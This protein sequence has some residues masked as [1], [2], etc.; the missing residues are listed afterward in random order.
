MRMT[1]A[2]RTLDLHGP[3]QCELITQRGY[4]VIARRLGPDPLR[5]D[6]DPEKVW[7][8]IRK[9]RSAIGSLLLNQAIIAG[10]GNVYRAEILFLSGVCPDRPGNQID[11]NEFDQIWQLSVDLL[12]VGV[13]Y[14]RIVTAGQNLCAQSL[15]RS[16]TRELTLIYQS[17]S[18]PRC[19]E[20]VWY[21]ELANRTI[22]ACQACQT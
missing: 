8:R 19:G 10:I 13:K 18:C 14:N 9:S 22:Y 15:S 5:N 3:N 16:S 20:D 17:E 2:N 12:N 21:W 6:A 11:R 4:R 1:G 7:E